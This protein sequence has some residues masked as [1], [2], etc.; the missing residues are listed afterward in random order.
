MR[1]TRED[2]RTPQRQRNPFSEKAAVRQFFQRPKPFTHEVLPPESPLVMMKED[3]NPFGLMR[4]RL[5]M[6]RN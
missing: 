3:R 4:E 6:I 2:E 5:V 1:I